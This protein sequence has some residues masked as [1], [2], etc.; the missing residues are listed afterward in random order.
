ML[1]LLRLGR[2]QFD[3]AVDLL[4]RAIR[5]RP[6]FPDAYNNLGVALEARQQFLKAEW[7]YRLAVRLNPSHVAAQCNLGNLVRKQ[8]RPREAMD[9]F[10]TALR[11]R[12]NDPIPH[13]GIG[14]AYLDL[15]QLD[16]ALF[17]YRKWS[18]LQP[19]NHTAHSDLLFW[20]LHDPNQTPE[21]LFQEHRRWS[22]RHERPFAD[23]LL[24]HGN[25]LV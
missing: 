9:I 25:V 10:G 19:R 18:D 6:R 23:T 8:A 3:D 12:P 13:G 2:G 14:A 15:G 5:A 7:A 21:S 4:R 22:E 17:H 16:I 11:L 1:G 24:P 20:L